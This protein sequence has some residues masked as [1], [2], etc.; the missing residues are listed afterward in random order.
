[1]APAGGGKFVFSTVVS[2]IARKGWIRP[3]TC[4]MH[5]Q[6]PDEDPQAPDGRE[7]AGVAEDPSCPWP[8]QDGPFQLAGPLP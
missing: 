1:M 5:E 4:G 6:A 8:V 7:M 2:E 3:V